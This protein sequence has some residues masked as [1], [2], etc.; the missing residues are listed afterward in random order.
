MARQWGCMNTT[1]YSE[2]NRNLLGFFCIVRIQS[3]SVAYLSFRKSTSWETGL[4]LRRKAHCRLMTPRRVHLKT[5]ENGSR[6]SWQQ[7]ECVFTPVQGSCGWTC[8]NGELITSSFIDLGHVHEGKGTDTA[9]ECFK[10]S[11]QAWRITRELNFFPSRPL[12][13]HYTKKASK[14]F[15]WSLAYSTTECCV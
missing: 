1:F 5:G 4:I 9:P 3:W 8:T 10:V 13:L 6:W 11:Q 12:S 2:I 14:T 15:L 7:G